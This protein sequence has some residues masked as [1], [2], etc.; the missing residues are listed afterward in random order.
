MAMP[1]QML[2]CTGIKVLI[3]LLTIITLILLDPTYVTA[4]I[5]VN[6]EIVFIYIISALSLLYCL[7]SIVMYAIMNRRE[8]TPMTNCALSEVVFAGAG[9]MGWLVVC[10]I[11]GTVSQRTIIETGEA[12]G[13]IGACAGIIVACFIA[14]A[15]VATLNVLN[16][17]VFASDRQS[18][19]RYAGARL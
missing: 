19:Y 10:G 15:G 11:A 9:M 8:D 13:W 2:I 18:K 16:E 6:Y 12:F 7:V 4:Y 3:I 5:S 17:K 1:H 14:I